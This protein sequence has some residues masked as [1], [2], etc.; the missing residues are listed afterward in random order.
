MKLCLILTAIQ[1][2]WPYFFIGNTDD[3]NLLDFTAIQRL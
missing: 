2:L 3:E 1:K